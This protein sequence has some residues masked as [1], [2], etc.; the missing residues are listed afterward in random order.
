MDGNHS[1]ND[2][3]E[4]RKTKRKVLVL[5]AIVMIL[6]AAVG[7]GLARYG[8]RIPI[9][10]PLFGESDATPMSEVGVREFRFE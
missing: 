8:E 10:G 2:R 7:I 9:V 4:Q 3:E 6:A 1:G 5:T